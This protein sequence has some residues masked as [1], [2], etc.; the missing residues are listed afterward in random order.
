MSE[1]I[2]RVDKAIRKETERYARLIPPKPPL[3]KLQARAA[4]EAMREPT[5]EMVD[6]AEGAWPK[7]DHKRGNL[8]I[9]HRAMIDEALKP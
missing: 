4:I 2:E 8:R 7:S 1:M 6:K 9:E 5:E 3:G